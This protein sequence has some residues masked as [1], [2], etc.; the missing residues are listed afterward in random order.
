MR[1]IGVHNIVIPKCCV[2]FVF[3]LPDKVSMLSV[4]VAF[5]ARNPKVA[6]AARQKV[7]NRQVVEELGKAAAQT[8]LPGAEAVAQLAASLELRAA[9]IAAARAA[10]LDLYNRC[11]STAVRGATLSSRALRAQH[12]SVACIMFGGRVADF[13]NQCV[14]DFECIEDAYRQKAVSSPTLCSL[15]VQVYLNLAARRSATES[16]DAAKADAAGARVAQEHARPQQAAQSTAKRKRAE[17]SVALSDADPATSVAAAVAD[18]A[19]REQTGEDVAERTAGIDEPAPPEPAPNVAA[20]KAKLKLV[21][22][23]VDWAGEAA[24]E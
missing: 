3:R 11:K 9:C 16:G 20:R 19:S 8:G 2:W 13:L 18:P 21:E 1:A 22:D 5:I 4:Q 14:F 12:R 15:S 24:T 7:L 23:D 6:R 17:E 10:E